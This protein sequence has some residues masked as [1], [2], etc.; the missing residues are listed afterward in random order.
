MHP[1]IVAFVVPVTT[2][3]AFFFTQALTSEAKQTKIDITDC[4]A[5]T[6][7]MKNSLAQEVWPFCLPS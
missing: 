5:M 7:V 2:F 4:T 3:T 6:V 1:R